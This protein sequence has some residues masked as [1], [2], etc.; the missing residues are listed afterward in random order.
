MERGAWADVACSGPSDSQIQGPKN[1][2]ELGLQIWGKNSCEIWGSDLD[3]GAGG[4]LFGLGET[5]SGVGMWWSL[6][7]PGGWQ[8][9]K[10]SSVFLSRARCSRFSPP[11]GRNRRTPPRGKE[12]T[13][14]PH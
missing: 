9:A 2:R 8:F 12:H 10:T 4:C 5:L 6:Y 14:T 1:A 7:S 13:P 3:L 11:G